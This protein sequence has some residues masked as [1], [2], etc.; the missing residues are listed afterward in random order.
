MTDRLEFAE[1][2]IGKMAVIILFLL[3]LLV[4][5]WIVILTGHA[6]DCSVVGGMMACTEGPDPA[7]SGEIRINTE[8]SPGLTLTDDLAYSG[9]GHIEIQLEGL[10]PTDE[11]DRLNSLLFSLWGRGMSIE[12]IS[13]LLA[14]HGYNVSREGL[15]TLQHGKKMQIYLFGGMVLGKV[16]A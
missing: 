6:A 4:G 10:E 1:E 7:I 2:T 13:Y 11:E 3:G 8:V 14:M 5:T 12:Q 9:W 15:V 16:E